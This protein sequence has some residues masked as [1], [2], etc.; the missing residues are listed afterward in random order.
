M[1]DSSDGRMATAIVIALGIIVASAVIGFSA[2]RIADSRAT[3][4]VTGPAKRQIVSDF[5]VWRGQFVAQSSQLAQAYA[6]L[7]SSRGR[8]RGYLVGRGLAANDLIFSPAGTR[9]FYATGPDRMETSTVTSYRLTQ[10]VEIRSADV[11]RLTAISRESTEL[12][13][14]GIAFESMPPEYLY[15]KLADLKVEML[16]E[17]TKD[18]RSRAQEMARNSGSRIGRLRSARMGVFQITSAYST[19][20]GDYGINDT[21]SLLKEITFG[22]EPELRGPMTPPPLA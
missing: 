12:I 6:D 11:E 10:T 15:K 17:A 16:A 5:V 4:T 22:R 18:A 14:Q 13:K 1:T 19:A 21:S 3:I 7:E 8:V 9:T 20:I 2:M